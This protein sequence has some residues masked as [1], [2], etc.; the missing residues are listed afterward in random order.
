[1]TELRLYMAQ[2]LTA[3]IMAPLV[4]GH[5]A[6]MI[7][8]VQSGLSA[9][10]ILGR[11]RGSLFWAL[12]YGTFVAAVSIHAAIGIRTILSEWAGFRGG[13]LNGVC[14]GVCAVLLVMG[15]RAVMAVTFA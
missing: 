12:F 4:I 14:I 6:V 3:L 2:R 9:G 5:I 11:T 13:L 10:E 15:G 1:M 8:A 7:Y